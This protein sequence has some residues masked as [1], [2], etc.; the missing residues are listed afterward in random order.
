MSFE[1]PYRADLSQD[2]LGNQELW[3]SLTPE[4]QIKLQE[5]LNTE[6]ERIIYLTQTELS[7]LRSIIGE[8]E[9]ISA[10]H[11]ADF[12]EFM[13]TQVQEGFSLSDII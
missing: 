7:E 4:E 2:N 11:D 9:D 5:Y 13:E 12:D 1:T 10:Q 3:D 6:H 8:D